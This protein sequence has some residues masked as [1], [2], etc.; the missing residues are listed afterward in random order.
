MRDAWEFCK[1]ALVSC[2]YGGYT[3]PV[4]VWL[5]ESIERVAST[6][7]RSMTKV[8]QWLQTSRLVASGCVLVAGTG[9]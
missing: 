5:P 4:V 6:R 1:S 8:V 7:S 9:C 3:T 2:Q